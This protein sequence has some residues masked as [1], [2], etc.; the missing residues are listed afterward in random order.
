M[1]IID[2]YIAHVL[3]IVRRLDANL[4]VVAAAVMHRYANNHELLDSSLPFGA[5]SIPVTL[6]LSVVHLL[7]WSQ[8]AGWP[9]LSFSCEL[10]RMLAF[11]SWIFFVDRRG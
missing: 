5:I 1:G 7:D 9:F 8:L 6:L 11:A 4:V 3:E 2:I 10:V